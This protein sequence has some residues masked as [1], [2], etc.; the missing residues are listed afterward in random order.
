MKIL[1]Y[2]K[3]I[4][5]YWYAVHSDRSM[6]LYSLYA[7]CNVLGINNG[8]FLLAVLAKFS[9]SR[10]HSL[11]QSSNAVH[12]W[13]RLCLTSYSWL[14]SNERGHC[15][16]YVAESWFVK[17]N[18]R[19]S[20]HFCGLHLRTLKVRSTWNIDLNFKNSG[21]WNLIQLC[22]DFFPLKQIRRELVRHMMCPE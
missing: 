19:C 8:A 2:F 15:V 10:F 6:F 21:K 5:N 1:S 12:K 17:F 13:R 4:I 3:Q 16:S 11:T 20:L 18:L 14:G 7:V 9:S 22:H